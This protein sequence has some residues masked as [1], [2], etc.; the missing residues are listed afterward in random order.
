MYQRYYGLRELPFELTSNP[1][2]LFFTPRHREALSTLEYGL[3]A[4]KAVTVLIG[5]AGTGKTTL[6]R[7]ALESE[8][9]RNVTCVYLHNPALTRAEFIEALSRALNLSAGAAE[10][11]ATLL[12]ELETVLRERRAAGQIVALVVD[13]AQSV[14]Y[15]LLEEV[16]LLGNIETATEK[17]LPLVLAGQP[18]FATRLNE[19]QLRQLK[20]RVALRCEITPLVLQETASYIASRLRAAGGD[21]A[22]LFTREAV[23]LIHEYSHGTPRT[24]SVICDNALVTAMALDRHRVD[25][26]IVLEVCADFDLARLESQLSARANEA[27]NAA[28]RSR[29]A[30]AEPADPPPA[31]GQVAS[32][33]TAADGAEGSRGKK[34]AGVEISAVSS[35]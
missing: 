15:E 2:F 25:R 11:K 6:L 32:A 27:D 33:G 1:R 28:D 35:S 8:G 30:S 29:A 4:A 12:Q 7:A 21:A 18:E 34:S 31:V 23:V 19:R 14:S 20:Q 3:S 10:S 16:R 22:R 9:C 24:V 26:Q 13:E 5:E 17:L